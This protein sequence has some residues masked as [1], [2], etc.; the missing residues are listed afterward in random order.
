MK[1]EY[2][3]PTRAEKKEWK[4]YLYNTLMF[5]ATERPDFRP[6]KKDSLE[7]MLE[8]FLYW[9]DEYNDGYFNEK[10]DVDTDRYSAWLVQEQLS[11]QD[12]D[13]FIKEYDTPFSDNDTD[14]KKTYKVFMKVTSYYY[15]YFEAENEEQAKELA[16]DA[17]D[18]EFK[19]CP[20]PEWEVDE[21]IE[22]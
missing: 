1:K 8:S 3:K 6:R 7:T 14:G 5:L 17:D 9:A 20:D 13:R 19:E 11:N 21:V 15:G 4:E 10:E 16:D 18:S 2:I 22:E 12:W